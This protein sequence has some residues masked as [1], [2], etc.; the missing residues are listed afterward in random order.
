VFLDTGATTTTMP[1]IKPPT[2]MK[3]VEGARLPDF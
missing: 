1:A 3:K 2:C